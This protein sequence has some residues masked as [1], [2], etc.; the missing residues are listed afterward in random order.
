MKQQ[1]IEKWKKKEKIDCGDR[2]V[3]V[4][5]MATADVKISI[6]GYSIEILLLHPEHLPFKKR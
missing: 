6:I 1:K 3:G 4:M 2:S 5:A